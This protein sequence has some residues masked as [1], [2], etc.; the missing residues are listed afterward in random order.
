MTSPETATAEATAPIAGETL[1]TQHQAF[2]QRTARSF[3]Y[4]FPKVEAE[5]VTQEIWVFLW[6]KEADFLANDCSTAYVRTCIKNVA[7]NYALKV[8]D[9]VL[10]ETD[11]F[12][13]SFDDVREMLPPFFGEP[14]G[15]ANA[16]VPDGCSTMTKN[17]NVEM[18][19]DL[20]I[21]YEKLNKSQRNVLMRRYGLGEELNGADRTQAS[22]ALKKLV[23]TLN[24]DTDQKAKAHH[25]P[26]SR[27]AMSSARGVYEAKVML[28]A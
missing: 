15:W 4:S 18:V 9:T 3:A 13:Y 26:G 14:E 27:K 7:R 19:C 6:E 2:I 24:S 10:L 25:G 17:D 1:W 11:T 16:P 8:R 5:D 21:A 28:D 23:L 12:Y 22:R 20:S